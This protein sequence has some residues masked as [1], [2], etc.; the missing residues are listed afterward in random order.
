MHANDDYLD[1]PQGC[2]G[3]VAAYPALSGSGMFWTRCER[4]YA[5]YVE[6]VAPRI[7]ETRRRYPV[8]APSDYDPLFAGESWDED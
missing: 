4:H 8:M 2:E 7:E 6:R 1:G 5:A 3:P